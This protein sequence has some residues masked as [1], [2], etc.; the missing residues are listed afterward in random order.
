MDVTQ[1]LLIVLNEK[2]HSVSIAEW[3][4]YSLYFKGI[5]VCH[6]LMVLLHRRDST[7][8]GSLYFIDIVNLLCWTLLY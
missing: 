7:T 8:M 3:A 1:V 4:I 2:S 5:F 6:L